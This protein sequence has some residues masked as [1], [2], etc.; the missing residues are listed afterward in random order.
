VPAAMKL[1]FR[2]S[3]SRAAEWVTRHLLGMI[4]KVPP[5]SIEWSRLDGP[6]FGNEVATL[7]LDGRAAEAVLEKSGP[8]TGPLELT[9]VGRV[10]LASPE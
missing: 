10:T 7:L 6:Y 4:S 2:I 5:M 1:A 3:W 8:S 9:E